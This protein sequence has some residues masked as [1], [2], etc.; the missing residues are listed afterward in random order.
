MEKVAEP[1]GGMGVVAIRSMLASGKSGCR[2]GVRHP[3]ITA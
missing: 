2:K 1:S 3:D